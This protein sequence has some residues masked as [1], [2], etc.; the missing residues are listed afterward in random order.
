M[1]F[2]IQAWSVYFLLR[3][4][5]KNG[6]MK[7]TSYDEKLKFPGLYSLQTGRLREDVIEA[8]KI[9]TRREDVSKTRSHL[10]SIAISD[11]M[12]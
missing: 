3:K 10:Q 6:A 8:F 2:C 12:I 11:A 5:T 7:N 1:K 4:G 9:L